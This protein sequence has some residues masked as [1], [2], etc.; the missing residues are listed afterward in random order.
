MCRACANCQYMTAFR[1]FQTIV[2][3]TRRKNFFHDKDLTV[4]IAGT[5]TAAIRC[6]CRRVRALSRRHTGSRY[7][8]T[9]TVAVTS[10]AVMTPAARTAVFDAPASEENIGTAKITLVKMSANRV[11]TAT[12]NASDTVT[13]YGFK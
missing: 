8:H 7:R 9:P 2:L 5:K 6:Q 10:V 3:R 11:I 13:P 1:S 4:S 12:A